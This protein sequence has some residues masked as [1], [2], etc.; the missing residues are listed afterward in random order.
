MLLEHRIGEKFDAII[1]GAADKG[2]WVRL[3]TLPVE[4]K[5][6]KTLNHPDVGDRVK[7]QLI[8]VD[9]DKGFIDFNEVD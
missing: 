5:L 3:I 4:G 7:V 6:M 9:V 1:T 2:T 8:G